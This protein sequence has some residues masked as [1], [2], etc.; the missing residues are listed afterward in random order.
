MQQLVVLFHDG[1]LLYAQTP[2][3]RF[4]LPVIE[5]EV[6]NVDTN[7]ER[8]ILPLSA[9]RQII[10]GGHL[11][12]PPRAE[13]A[14]W[15]RAAFHFSDGHV[16]RAWI[17]PDARLGVHGGIWPMVEPDSDE[18]RT[19]AIPYTSL[20]GVFR[21]RQWDSRSMSERALRAAGE[22]VHLEQ[23]VRVLAEREVR[24]SRRPR[25]TPRRLIDRVRA[26]E[27]EAVPEGP[28]EET[29]A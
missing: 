26:E 1:E 4:D 29:P 28:V 13:L 27:P 24:S 3:L 9:I 23:M 12:A 8:A 2:E 20:K 16:M 21:L 11:P 6:I 25:R 22:P 19:V 18:L 7:S 14:D 15:D 17:G 10:V 5:A